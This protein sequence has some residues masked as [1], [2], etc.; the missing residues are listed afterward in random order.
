MKELSIHTRATDLSKVTEILEKYKAVVSFYQV[1]GHGRTK[2]DTIPEMV[3]SYMTGRAITPE[4]EQRTK[5]ETIV[6]DSSAKEIVEDLLSN[7]PGPEPLGMI[8]VKEVSNAYEI[9]TKQSGEA[10]LTHN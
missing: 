1:E 9:G 6:P 7:F 5:V 2:R 3:R 8:F 4:F 10:V